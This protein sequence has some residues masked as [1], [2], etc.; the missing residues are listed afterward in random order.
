LEELVAKR[1]KEL[2]QSL[3]RE[4]ILADM[5]RCAS[6]AIDVAYPDGRVTHCNPAFL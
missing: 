2:E 4:K 1:T 6:I 3:E 5:V